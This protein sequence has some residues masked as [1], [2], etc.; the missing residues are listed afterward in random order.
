MAK[1]AIARILATNCLPGL[2]VRKAKAACFSVD[3]FLGLADTLT[4]ASKKLKTVAK[5][6]PEMTRQLRSG[7][8]NKRP[9]V[10]L[11]GEVECDEVY[12]VAGH[13]G[14]EV[15]VVA[16]HKGQPE[17][18]KKGRKGRC[19]RL[20][21]ARGRGT[22]A[23]EKPPILGM[24]QRGGTVAIQMLDNVQQTTIQLVIQNTIAPGTLIYTDEWSH[25]DTLEKAFV[26]VP[27]NMQQFSV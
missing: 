27:E 20:K 17:A 2:A 25:G 6:Q 5:K 4:E 23:K 10:V 12:V 24:I 18:V 1:T 21:G 14:Q 26:M 9:A 22:L 15:Y 8:V 11:E 3:N 19:N 7:I 13:K 16:G